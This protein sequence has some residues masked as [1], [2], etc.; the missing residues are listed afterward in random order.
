MLLERASVLPERLQLEQAA[1]LI[2]RAAVLLERC[3]VVR[4]GGV[5]FCAMDV[6]FFLQV[7]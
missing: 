4:I 2:E 3:R 5:G 1:V 7:R 6:C